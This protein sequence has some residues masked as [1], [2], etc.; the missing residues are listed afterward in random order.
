V[1]KIGRDRERKGGEEGRDG[2]RNNLRLASSSCVVVSLM[3]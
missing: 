2:K 3:V 1:R